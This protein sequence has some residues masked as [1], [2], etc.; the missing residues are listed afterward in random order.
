MT[1][2]KMLRV[3]MT[4]QT[5]RE[6]ALPDRYAHLGGRGLVDLVMLDEVEPTCDPLGP[7]NKLLFATGLFAGHV[8]VSSAGRLSVG[9]KSPL[10]GGIKEA[11]GGGTVAHKLGRLGYRL[12]VVEGEPPAGQHFVLKIDSGG[13]RLLAAGDLWGLPTFASCDALRASHG[14]KI[15]IA[16]IGPAGERGY[17]L[18]GIAVTD[19]EGGAN[20][21]C[22][23][24]GVGAV[25]AKRGLKAVVVDDAGCAEPAVANR[26]AFR[27]AA[28]RFNQALLSHPVTGDTYPRLGTPGLVS[29]V[30]QIGAL[31][32]NNFSSGVFAAADAISGEN[33]YDVIGQRG[34]QGRTTHSCMP[35]CVIRSSN[36]FADEQGC[37]LC[38]PIEFETL[39]LCGSNLGLGTLDAVAEI[40]RWCNEFGV[41]T[42]ELGATLGVAMEAGLAQFG[43]LEG[44]RS[45]LGEM[46]RDTILGKVLGSATVNAAKVLGVTRVPTVLGQAVSAYDPRVVKGNGVT[47]MTSPQGAD[48]TAGNTIR[49]KVEHTDPAGKA[50]TSRAAQISAAAIDT[51]NLCLFA[52]AVVGVNQELVRDLVAAWSGQPVPE[53]YW[54]RLG[55][56]VLGYEWR[57]N[58]LAGVPPVRGRL[59]ELYLREPLAPQGTVFD[60]PLEEI[61][62]LIRF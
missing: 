36:I 14:D 56:E 9:T 53:D 10:T 2:A 44:V 50:A 23:R 12:I 8:V 7:Y 17:L 39:G 41:D 57:F 37:A 21:Y 26:E 51:V 13:A 40:N 52:G 60:V 24:G 4:N 29:Y 42:I 1:V 38:S 15:G 58:D 62:E 61:E 18:S 59:P 35:G 43:D 34:G 16:T 47:Y 31:P 11:N 22:A 5:V 6:E 45:L 25:M 27:A 19:M 32:T 20:R 55:A 48:H 54:T 28:K 33:L 49:L 30:N 3:D 46:E